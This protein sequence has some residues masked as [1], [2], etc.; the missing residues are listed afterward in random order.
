MW[1]S[2][3]IGALL[4]EMPSFPGVGRRASGV[5]VK[6]EGPC[7]KILPPHRNPLSK[8]ANFC[9]N[10]SKARLTSITS[11]GVHYFNPSPAT[12]R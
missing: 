9:E 3:D 4:E 11:P 6:K 7:R 5:Q 12:R 2:S 8:N 10:S 1:M